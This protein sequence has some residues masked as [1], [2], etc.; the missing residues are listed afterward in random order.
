MPALDQN[1]YLSSRVDDQLSWL[2]RA[3]KAN[4]RVF[5][6]M[7]IFEILL[8]TS[9]TIFSPFANKVGWAPLAIA[10]AGGG[11]ALSGG[12]LALCRNQENWVR[13][14]SLNE[15]LKCEKYLFLTGSPPYDDNDEQKSFTRF[16]AATEALM[17][18]ER[19]GWAKLVSQKADAGAAG[20]PPAAGES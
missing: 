10:V 19:A 1:T 14:R 8:G 9:I 7:R 6:S 15:A 3:S 16:V 5:L 13:Y 2:S 4:K 12:W 20:T 18:G 11:I 17:S